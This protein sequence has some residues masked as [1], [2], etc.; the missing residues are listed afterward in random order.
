MKQYLNSKKT[1]LLAALVGYVIIWLLFPKY[2]VPSDPSFYS[3]ISYKMVSGTF[4]HNVS[5]YPFEHRLAVTVPTALFY[6]L[7]G[8]NDFST[9]LWP[10]ICSLLLIYGLYKVT[11][12][13]YIFL[14]AIVFFMLNRVQFDLAVS[15][16]PDT[17]LSCFMFLSAYT[18]YRRDRIH[19][20]GYL[21]P[22]A[23]VLLLFL[24]GLAKLSVYWIVPMWVVMLGYDLKKRR[25][26]LAWAYYG[27][28]VLIGLVVLAGYLVFCKLV[29]GSYLARLFTTNISL[30]D[31]TFSYPITRAGELVHRIF[32]AMPHMLLVNFGI[33]PLLFLG[34]LLK[35]DKRYGFWALYGGLILF[36]FA[37]GTVNFHHY[38]VLTL[39][40]RYI[41][42][43]LPVFSLVGAYAI[44]TYSEYVKKKS[45]KVVVALGLILIV[46]M[47]FTY[48][49]YTD[50]MIGESIEQ[51]MSYVKNH[52]INNKEKKIVLLTYTYRNKVVL[53]Y[54]FGYKRTSDFNIQY[55]DGI[56]Y[57]GDKNDSI[58]LIQDERPVHFLNNMFGI[59]FEKLSGNFR[60]IYTNK[61]LVIYK[62]HG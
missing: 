41:I 51:T 40:P 19:Q 47:P 24:A 15:L 46:A 59:K 14:F 42:Y 5:N 10:L 17:I 26:N 4:F 43:V 53:P 39:G 35:I 21:L 18:L 50:A 32:L 7:F 11:D 49:V 29:W 60:K 3:I 45:Y 22:L 28:M 34:G 54:Y 23:T 55:M 27:R 25:Y 31:R 6:Y 56:K 36:F 62:Y 16:F 33:L 52:L 48:R 57:E 1:L 8:V 44:V 9:N 61:N 12:N 38:Y 20:Y 2:I 13:K 30:T 58:Y 37:F